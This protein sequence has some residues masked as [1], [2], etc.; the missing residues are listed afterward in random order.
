MVSGWRI[1]LTVL[2]TLTVPVPQSPAVPVPQSSEFHDTMICQKKAIVTD[3]SSFRNDR[4][5][6]HPL[7]P[8]YLWMSPR[9]SSVFSIMIA[10]DYGVGFAC[11]KTQKG[12]TPLKNPGVGR[13]SHDSGLSSAR[14]EPGSTVL[15]LKN[16]CFLPKC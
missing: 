1:T 4:K 13:S 15:G 5:R 14:P 6:F 8:V 16:N 7:L 10:S 3:W 2:E 12:E 9:V 11:I